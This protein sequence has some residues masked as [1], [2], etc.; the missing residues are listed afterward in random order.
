[1][2]PMQ[3]PCAYCGAPAGHDCRGYGLHDGEIHLARLRPPPI[4]LVQ[5]TEEDE[6]CQE[7]DEMRPSGSAPKRP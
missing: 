7:Q 5:S 1:M 6:R 3:R 4:R 2:T